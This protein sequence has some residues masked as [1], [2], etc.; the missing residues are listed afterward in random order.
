M[1]AEIEI[2]EGVAEI[3]ID[4]EV[5]ILPEEVIKM[6]EIDKEIVQGKIHFNSIIHIY[7]I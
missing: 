2:E 3:E 7:F 4:I 6:I 1:I 5:D